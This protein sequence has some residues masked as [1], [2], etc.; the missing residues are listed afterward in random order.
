MTL[1]NRKKT[2][3]TRIADMVFGLQAE[4]TIYGSETNS[5]QRRLMTRS[6][7]C[8]VGSEAENIVYGSARMPMT[9]SGRRGGTV[10]NRESDWHEV[11]IRNLGSDRHGVTVRGRG[12]DCLGS[13]TCRVR[14]AEVENTLPLFL[15][16]AIGK[17]TAGG[18]R[19]RVRS[20]S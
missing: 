8:G 16:T 9:Q 18:G 4:N 6:E 10:R 1:Y 7:Q 19:R 11:A 3:T 20:S 14:L 12:S 13:G 15:G 2:T 5:D 17:D